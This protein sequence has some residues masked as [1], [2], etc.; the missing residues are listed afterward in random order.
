MSNG[1]KKRERAWRG[2]GAVKNVRCIIRKSGV[3]IPV[4]TYEAR[5]LRMPLNPA[6]REPIPSLS[7]RVCTNPT[8]TCAYAHEDIYTQT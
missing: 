5:H 2:G 1:R 6:P 7:L 8:N 4:P 3:Q